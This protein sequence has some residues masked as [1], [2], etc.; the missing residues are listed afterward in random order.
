METIKWPSRAVLPAKIHIQPTSCRFHC[1]ATARQ[2]SLQMCPTFTFPPSHANRALIPF[3]LPCLCSLL[4]ASPFC[5][6]V[7]A[8][9]ALCGFE[10]CRGP[11]P[12]AAIRIRDSPACTRPLGGKRD[13]R[14]RSVKD[15][16]PVSR[17]N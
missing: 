8:S 17:L 6:Y 1:R 4:T 16:S 3:L 15:S 14:L 11:F 13:S 10:Q 9:S 12:V 5:V 7:G 2:R